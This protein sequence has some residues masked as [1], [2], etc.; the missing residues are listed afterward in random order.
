MTQNDDAS[1]TMMVIYILESVLPIS[2]LRLWHSADNGRD[3]DVVVFG[4]SQ[5][6]VFLMD[7]VCAIYNKRLVFVM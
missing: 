5:T 1:H 2:T 4:G 3:G 7:S 6:F